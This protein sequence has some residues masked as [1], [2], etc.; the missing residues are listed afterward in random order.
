MIRPGKKTRREQ[1]NGTE[2]QKQWANDILAPAKALIDQFPNEIRQRHAL[3]LGRIES[4]ATVIRCRGNIADWCRRVQEWR[5]TGV[6]WVETMG[7]AY[8]EPSVIR[9][10]VV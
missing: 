8:T 1:M 9:S 7:Q 5:T 6:F 10:V 4:A 3:S 2:A